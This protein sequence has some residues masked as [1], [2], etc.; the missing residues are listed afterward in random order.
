MAKRKGFTLIELIVVIAIIALLVTILAPS[1]LGAL[2]MAR[3][4]VC[5][6]R[7]E[8]IGDGAHAYAGTNTK[9]SLPFRA[10]GSAALNGMGKNWWQ[11]QPD[12]WASDSNSRPWYMLVVE[13]MVPVGS[14]VCP[15]DSE[16]EPLISGS[17]NWDFDSSDAE[18]RPLSYGL[19]SAVSYHSANRA[20]DPDSHRM[21][22]PTGLGTKHG[23]SFVI[24]ADYS[25]LG[26]YSHAGNHWVSNRDGS[27]T[28]DEGNPALMN[29]ENHSRRGQNVL[30]LDGHV[31]FEETPMCGVDGD[32]IWTRSGRTNGTMNW[33]EDRPAGW[34]DTRLAP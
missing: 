27:V 16:A 28:M 26:E 11:W 30:R 10:D 4:A 19:Q 13:G 32:N 3:K 5:S 31:S 8:N 15:S 6:S 12:N 23:S 7:L 2:R 29:S 22:K 14:F 18:S 21:C 9:R 33:A 25:G 34:Y 1:L 24:A 20:Y 17:G